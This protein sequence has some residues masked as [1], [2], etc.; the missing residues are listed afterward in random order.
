MRR[1]LLAQVTPN[2]ASGQ[3]EVSYPKTLNLGTERGL[4]RTGLP[5]E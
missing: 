2:R 1:K 5:K 3:V 4:V